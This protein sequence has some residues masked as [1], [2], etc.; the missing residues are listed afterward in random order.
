MR[1]IAFILLSIAALVLSS[2][3]GHEPEELQEPQLVVN[4][5]NTSGDWKLVEWKGNIMDPSPVYLRLKNK[6]FVLWQS[7]G[8]MYPTKVTGSYNLLEED[9]NMIMRGL[10]D[11]TYEYWNH[12]YIVSSLTATK[13]EWTSVD[14][15]TDISLYERTEDFPQE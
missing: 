6:E 14:D 4:F 3:G 5:T 2:C 1:K 11:Y 10:Y 8:S 15:P 9:G 13:M 12:K 7:T